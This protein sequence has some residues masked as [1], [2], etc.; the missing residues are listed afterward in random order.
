MPVDVLRRLSELAQSAVAHLKVTSA[1]NP[2]LWMCATVCSLCFATAYLFRDDRVA[3]YL[4]LLVGMLP[5]F[6]TCGIA[7]SSPFPSRRSY[8]LKNIS[9]GSRR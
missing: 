4:L 9:F 5:I 6:L 7:L 2:L 3:K 8:N 1:L